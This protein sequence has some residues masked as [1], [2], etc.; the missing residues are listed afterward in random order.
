M[1]GSFFV[2]SLQEAVCV[3]KNFCKNSKIS[4]LDLLLY[5]SNHR[6]FNCHYQ[7]FKMI[8]KI[9]SNINSLWHHNQWI[10]STENWKLVSLCCCRNCWISIPE[11][12]TSATCKLV[13][14]ETIN[15][16]MKKKTKAERKFNVKR[17]KKV[18][19]VG[20]KKVE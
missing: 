17:G 6:A 16:D 2:Y 1:F 19:G 8:F 3:W 11:M 4:Q 7:L 15:I 9:F 20:V 5:V 18:E 12:L 10:L 14:Y 13:N